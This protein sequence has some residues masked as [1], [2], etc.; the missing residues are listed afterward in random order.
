MSH[1]RYLLIQSKVENVARIE[2]KSNGLQD[3]FYAI[4]IVTNS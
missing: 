1:N 2:L 4:M 3:K